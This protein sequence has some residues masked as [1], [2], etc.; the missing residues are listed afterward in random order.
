MQHAR[1]VHA[2][3]RPCDD[4]PQM[5]HSDNFGSGRRRISSR[6]LYSISLQVIQCI[7]FSDRAQ[8]TIHKHLSC[9]VRLGLQFE[10]TDDYAYVLVVRA[11]C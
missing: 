5:K 3:E 7:A 2:F 9:S 10:S 6:I 1:Y 11:R 8:A 4:P